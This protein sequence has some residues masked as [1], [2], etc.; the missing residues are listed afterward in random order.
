ACGISGMIQHVAGME[1]S[2]FIVAVNKNK[3]APIFAY[4][5]I[6]IVTDVNSLLPALQE[7]LSRARSV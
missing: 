1:E 5:D 7:E 4:A 2:G 3:D 6:G